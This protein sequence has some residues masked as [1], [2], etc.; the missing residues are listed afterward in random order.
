LSNTGSLAP[1]RPVDSLPVPSADRRR[2]PRYILTLAVTLHGDNN[3]Y[4]G[5][6][7]DISQS[8]IFIATCHVLPIGTPVMLEFTLPESRHA[9]QVQGTV[10]WVREPDFLH[11]HHVGFGHRPPPGM[12]VQFHD[13]D[14]LAASEIRWFM[15]RR[16]PEFYD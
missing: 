8:G 1:Q 3:F 14:R 16:A 7:E 9:L 12:G 11:V 2:H 6:S 15:R 13:L 10:Q 5:L 4:T